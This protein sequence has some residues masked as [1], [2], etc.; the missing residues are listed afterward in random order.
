MADDL[1]LYGDLVPSA[2]VRASPAPAATP[3]VM[4]PPT[5][6]LPEAA[7]VQEDTRA[8]ATRLREA[9]TASRAPNGLFGNK[10]W[11]P[12]GSAPPPSPKRDP[13][14]MLPPATMQ[15]AA[16]AADPYFEAGIVCEPD[17]EI[18]CCQPR[19]DT[20]SRTG[21][22]GRPQDFAALQ[23]EMLALEGQAA[24]I[25][26]G[27]KTISSVEDGGEASEDSDCEAVVMGEVKASQTGAA[28]R[29][30]FGSPRKWA[31]PR[32]APG[33]PLAEQDG[34]SAKRKE[35]S[36]YIGAPPVVP[37]STGLA[38]CLV[39]V[40]GLPWW[41]SDSE[42]RRH[43]EVFGQIRSIRILD[44]VRSGK[45]AGIALLEFVAPD[46]A[47]RAARPQEGLCGLAAWQ[48]MAIAPPRLVQ[49]SRELFQMLRVGHLPWPDGGACTED[50]RSTLM[51]LFGLSSS[52]TSQGHQERERSRG[53]QRDTY[54][55]GN[56]GSSPGRGRHRRVENDPR[57]ERPPSTCTASPAPEK[58]QPVEAWADKLKR[59]SGNVN[60]RQEEP[61]MEAARRKVNR[62]L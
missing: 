62:R 50:L 22:P 49:V 56:R 29:P 59:L 19:V 54:R 3:P 4:S 58:P 25:S 30:P 17:G 43:A 24:P 28:H 37:Q 42:L 8:L 1:D 20:S 2:P 23:Q 44:Y 39:L 7:P 38:D 27:A 18:S 60:K 32:P 55:D 9:S 10:V 35:V 47:Q 52:S 36:L 53:R 11:V 61:G 51:R 21:L 34:S 41:L 26:P 57:L 16:E 40:G 5:A 6:P 31:A 15:A 12:P 45:S 48:A 33:A 14:P 46:S 13:R